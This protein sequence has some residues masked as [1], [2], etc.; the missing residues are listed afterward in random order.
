MKGAYVITDRCIAC[1]TC[2][3]ACRRGCIAG[4]RPPFVI[5]AAWCSGCG[6][7]AEKCPVK[8]ILRTEGE[9][10]EALGAS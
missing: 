5:R 1:G 4:G 10:D 2:L 3:A 7:C 6:L 9:A 8:A